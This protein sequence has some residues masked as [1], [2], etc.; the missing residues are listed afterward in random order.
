MPMHATAAHQTALVR[1]SPLMSCHV[2]WF[3]LFTC[4]CCLR[5]R[6]DQTRPEQNRPGPNGP[7]T[8]SHAPRRHSDSRSNSRS[9]S[10]SDTCTRYTEAGTNHGTCLPTLPTYPPTLPSHVVS[11][12]L[13]LSLSLPDLPHLAALSALPTPSPLLAFPR[14][15]QSTIHTCTYTFQGRCMHDG[16]VR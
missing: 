15:P 10:R 3:A 6:L 8:S 1:V 12:S 14:H 7:G 11:L 4:H 2:E 16:G 9:R 13:S 5:H